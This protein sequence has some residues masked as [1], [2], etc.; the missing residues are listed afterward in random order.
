[1]HR[2][3]KNWMQYSVSHVALGSAS[4][5]KWP[6]KQFQS[7]SCI[8][9]N[10]RGRKLLRI[11]RL[12]RAKGCHTPKFRG[13]NFRKHPQTVKFVKVFSRKSFP[14]YD[15]FLGSMPPDPPTL[16]CMPLRHP[17][18]PP[19]KNP[20]YGPASVPN[21]SIAKHTFTTHTSISRVEAVV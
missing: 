17:C 13:E 5:P 7:F 8:A 16:A 3:A 9:G 14:L 18:N 21:Y 15:N 10:F 4:V 2:T 20:A 12:C 6:Q 1:M 19:S 11:A